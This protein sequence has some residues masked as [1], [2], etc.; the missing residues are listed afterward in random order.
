MLSDGHIDE[1][2]KV[3]QFFGLGGSEKG[4]YTK[5]LMS[6]TGWVDVGRETLSTDRKAGLQGNLTFSQ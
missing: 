6:N 1:R 4:L 2:S 3:K 5:G